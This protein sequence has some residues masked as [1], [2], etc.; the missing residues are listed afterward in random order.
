MGEGGGSGKASAAFAYVGLWS[1]QI[2]AAKAFVSKPHS[3]HAV[4]SACLAAEL[5][6]LAACAAALRAGPAALAARAWADARAGEQG[7]T[8]IAVA[9]CYC[10]YN[11]MASDPEAAGSA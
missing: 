8:L 7:V 1:A 11:L 9:L 10:V 2:L 6:K 4:V 5:L 3:L